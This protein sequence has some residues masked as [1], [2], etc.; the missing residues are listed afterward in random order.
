[1]EHVVADRR[2]AET[3]VEVEV[4]SSVA[5]TATF[6]ASVPTQVEVH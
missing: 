2:L 4:V 5:R 1:M 3:R 6:H